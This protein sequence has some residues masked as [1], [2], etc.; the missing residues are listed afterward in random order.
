LAELKP[1]VNFLDS[2]SVV[3][4]FSEAREEALGVNAPVVSRWGGGVRGGFSV[5]LMGGLW[6]GGFGDWLKYFP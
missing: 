6:W 5:F 4:E 3:A 2:Y 1:H